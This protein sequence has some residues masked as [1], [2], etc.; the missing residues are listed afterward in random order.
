[1]HDHLDMTTTSSFCINDVIPSDILQNIFLLSADSFND[2]LR[3]SATCQ[4]WRKLI[5]NPFMIEHYW[6]FDDE[7][8]KKSLVR[9]WNFDA[10]VSDPGNPFGIF[11][12]V[13]CFLGKCALIN[14]KVTSEEIVSDEF[15]YDIDRGSDY[16]VALWLFIGA[17]GNYYSSFKN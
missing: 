2:V 5:F 10:N 6:T 14:E 17:P 8:R 4:L 13:D 9:W 11:P 1:M 15:Q 12:T 3:I 7:H 16:T